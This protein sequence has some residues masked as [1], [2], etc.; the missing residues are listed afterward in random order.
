VIG[1]EGS[2]VASGADVGGVI[3]AST[4]AVTGEGVATS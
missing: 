4:A 1:V 3:E 2:G